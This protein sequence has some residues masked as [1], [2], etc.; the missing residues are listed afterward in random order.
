MVFNGTDWE[1]VCLG[2]N[3]S[4]G[5]TCADLLAEGKT[6]SGRYRIDPNGGATSDAFYAYCDMD[7]LDE[8]GD[9]SGCSSRRSRATRSTLGSRPTRRS[10]RPCGTH[11]FWVK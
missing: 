8:N 11:W 7:T 4:S 1:A 5:I 10:A 2:T 6:T 3:T 9:S